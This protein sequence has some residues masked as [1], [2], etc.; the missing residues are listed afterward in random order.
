MNYRPTNHLKSR[1]IRI[2]SPHIPQIRGG[3]VAGHWGRRR[4]LSGELTKF[5]P[6]TT[7]VRRQSRAERDVDVFQRLPILGWET[8]RLCVPLRFL[9][10]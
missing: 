4:G 7:E 1:R 5:Y 2:A 10:R 8:L 6:R 9:R 3:M